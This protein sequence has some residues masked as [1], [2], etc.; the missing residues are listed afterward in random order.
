MKRRVVSLDGTWQVVF[1]DK[2]EGK[3]KRFFEKMPKGKAIDV[4]GVWEEVR[5]M[6]DGA[7][8]YQRKFTVKPEWKKQAIR[9]RFDAVNY[10]AEV[11]LNG[12][13]IGM[14]EGGYTPFEFD[15]TSKVR[16]GKNT[17][18]VRVVDPPRRE[19]VDGLRSGAPLSNADIPTWKAGWYW[20]FG[21]IWQSV[22]LIITPKVYI[23]NIF[24]EPLP[25]KRT[26][27]VHVTVVAKTACKAE[28][29]LDVSPWKSDEKTGGAVTK[30]VNLKRGTRTI[31]MPVKIARMQWWDT[32]NPFLYVARATLTSD[33]GQD[34]VSDRFGMRTF[35]VKDNHFTL[36]GKRIVL[37]GFLQQGAYPEKLAYAPTKAML[38]KELELSKA[39]GLNFIRLHLKPDPFT[40]ELADEMGV[41][42]VAEPPA[43]WVRNTPAIYK[44]CR[45][46]AEELVK[47]DR[48]HP[49]IVMWCMLN[50]IYHYWTF[51]DRERDKLRHIM[52]YRAREL[53]PT[54]IIGDNSGGCHIGGECAGAL[55][56]YKKTY[57]PFH[58]LH[59][60]CQ[61]PVT[62]KNLEDRYL[63]YKQPSGPIYVSEFGAFE[64][65]PLWDKMLKRYSAKAKRIGTDD[66]R[67]YKSFAESF[68]KRFRQAGLKDIFGSEKAFI[69][70]QQDQ[71][72][73]DVRAAVS[74]M[75]ANPRIDAYAICQLAD[76]SGEI[77]GATD[78]W[79]QPKKYYYEFARAA[80]TPWIVPHLPVRIVMPGGEIPV[81]LHC[82]N[83]HTT[84][85]KYS[86]TV[87]LKAESGGRALGKWQKTFTARG[88]TQQVAEFALS[89]PARGGRYVVEAV[90][91]EGG[92]VRS[93]NSLR[94][95]VVEMPALEDPNLVMV[96]PTPELKAAMKLAGA[97][98][99]NATNSTCWKNDPFVF[100][101]ADIQVGGP[102]FEGVQQVSRMVRLGGVAVIFEP[103][104]PIFYDALLPKVIRLM[105]P[106]RT[107]G[108]VHPHPVTEGVPTGLLSYE[109]SDLRRGV[110]HVAED[111][112]AAGGRTIIGGIGANMWTQPD[113]YHWTGLL[114]E[115]PVGRGKVLLVQM[116][117]LAHAKANP[118]AR[119]LLRNLLAY[120][121]SSI[122][123]GLEDRCIG[124]CIDPITAP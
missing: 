45:R 86:V 3:R 107:I 65:P 71:C 106:M 10:L 73:E 26:A 17:L 9:L 120:A 41:L 112:R 82:V 22:Q 55:M 117:L 20:N 78:I 109:M 44:R 6:Y 54:R 42:L 35:T 50:E 29:A 27:K 49:S 93:S 11:Y 76:A 24:V 58:D 68:S 96:R 97:A 121:R 92:K 53:D 28:I 101:G 85:R 46:E 30:T 79:R 5:P 119:R 118:V 16:A 18:T 87:T 48:N 94:V 72:G 64:C 57:S 60:Y 83:E 52:S 124:R 39:H 81:Q 7:G 2:N 116:D 61:L 108:Y 21:G 15:V 89:A 75:R 14:H 19:V 95:T 100:I 98:T 104:T 23:D 31:T 91:K 4:P 47:R 122:K 38:R 1:D 115:V 56:P 63:N 102:S 43:G 36:N 114:D 13:R 67:Q 105:S 37:K 123:P 110:Q 8:W 51:T 25:D 70:A 77:F 80:Q 111:V 32:E 40:P 88:W 33:A 12:K 66:Y 74:A 113:I 90:L 84:G 59:Q 103:R 69:L 99:Y 62:P 34:V